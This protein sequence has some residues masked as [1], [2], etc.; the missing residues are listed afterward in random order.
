MMSNVKSYFKTVENQ[1]LKG[2]LGPLLKGK[3][4]LRVQVANNLL[5]HL[6]HWSATNMQ[7]FEDVLASEY[8]FLSIQVVI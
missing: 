2:S 1:L 3:R 4:E 8:C 5:E 6:F 7:S